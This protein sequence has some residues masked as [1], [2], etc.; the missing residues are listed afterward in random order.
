MPDRDYD[1]A[2]LKQLFHYV[3]RAA[4]AR[5][6]F[7]AVKLYKVAWFSDARAYMLYGRSITGATYIKKEFGPIP[8]HGRGIRAALVKEGLISEHRSKVDYE[9]WTFRSL[10]DPGP[11]EFD[12]KE[13]EIINYW[14]KHIDE[15]HT[16]G[17]ISDLTHDYG[18]EIADIG[19]ELPM[20]AFMA[21]RVREPTDDEMDTFKTWAR[22]IGR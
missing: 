10:R 5:P 14:I 6:G 13:L 19:E 1:P 7:G 11:L 17:S 21:N 20:A 15:D 8:K 3:I 12:S 9:G 16:A 22:E 18:W 2:R 4:G